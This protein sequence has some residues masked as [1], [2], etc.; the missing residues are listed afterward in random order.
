MRYVAGYIVFSLK[1]KVERKTSPE[2]KAILLLLNQFSK[3]DSHL[4]EKVS[5]LE[6]TSHWVDQVN[7]RGLVIVNDQFYAF[8]KLLEHLTRVLMNKNLFIKYCGEDLRKILIE[9][10]KNS[11]AIQDNWS[12]LTAELRNKDLGKKV[13][14]AI[15]K[16]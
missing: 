14:Q 15:F 6:Y 1:K 16:I 8:I 5:L 2:S 10:F 13:L 3:C 12:D 9:L 7:R 11:G 4:D